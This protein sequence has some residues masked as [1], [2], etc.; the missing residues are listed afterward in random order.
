MAIDYVVNYLCEPKDQ[1]TTQ[2]ILARLKGRDQA[3]RIIKLYR[4]A[5]DDRPPSEMGFEL[6]RSA[7]DG[8]EETETVRVSQILEASA[9][10]DPL[11]SHCEGCPANLRDE[12]FGCFGVI[13]YPL[14]D[15]AERWLLLQLPLPEQAP[16]IWTLLQQNL[17]DLNAR[18][19]QV[20]DI[21]ESGTYFESA[22]NP[23]RKLGEIAISG[24]NLFYFLFMQGHVSPSRAAM[25]LLIFD[26]IPRNLDAGDIFKLAPAPKDAAERFPFQLQPDPELDDASVR[27]LK[28]FF[29]AMYTAWRLNVDLQLDV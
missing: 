13:N 11:A 10:L 27:D 18:S 29:R 2:G 15:H 22:L 7:A 4:D 8:T 1:L 23:R 26:A 6:T 3:R 16:L 5:G 19:K 21:R 25:T 9:Q 24:N 28:A 17:R 12:P 14:S 20:Q